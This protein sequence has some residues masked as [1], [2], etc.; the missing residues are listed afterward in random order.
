MIFPRRIYVE[1]PSQPG[2]A[3]R[4]AATFCRELGFNELLIAQVSLVVTELAT[5]LVKHTGNAGGDLVFIP[6]E[7]EGD[8]GLDVLSLDLA[9]GIASVAESLRDGYSTTDTHGGGLGA[10]RRQSS[11]F[12]IYS[13]FGKGTALLSR[14][15]LETTAQSNHKMRIG[16]VCLPVKGEQA[17][18]DAWATKSLPGSTLFLLADGLG[19]GPEAALAA[20]LAVSIFKSASAV[21]PYE[22]ISLVNNALGHTRGAAVAIA[23]IVWSQKKINF[24]GIG[25]ISGAVFGDECHF[26]LVS[27]NGTAG[28]NA[29]HIMEFEYPWPHN[30]LL[31]IHSDGLSTHW[32]LDD[33]PGLSQKHPALIAGVL[34]RD[35]QR[36]R[37]DSC[38]L[39]ARTYETG[40]QV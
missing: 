26:N 31:I 30:G 16:S 11:D 37:D 23:E 14:F 33:Y 19:H 20:N 38:I 27:H 25:N 36:L 4:M 1:D 34:F 24:A 39:V 22:L 18:G 21:R 28:V 29:P 9:E 17:C 7:V 13:I 6:F 8:V 35:Y 5:N 40:I 2:E 10:I 3:R 15:W 12:D 32:S